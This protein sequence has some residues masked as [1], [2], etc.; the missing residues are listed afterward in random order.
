MKLII[1]YDL[2]DKARQAKT[3]FSLKRHS[4]AVGTCMAFVSP[5]LVV[6]ATIGDR[7]PLE[8]TARTLGLFLYYN[9]YYWLTQKARA[10]LEMEKAN[11]SLRLLSYKLKDIFV[12]TD[13][14]LLQEVVAYK[15]KYSLDFESSFF[16]RIEQKKYLTVPVHS[17]WDNNTRSLVQEHIIG[18]KEYTLAHGEPEQKKVYSLGARKLM[19][20]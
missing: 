2:P 12:D 4:K 19:Q 3:G 11:E 1:N 6:D 16:P 8:M 9:L 20:K 18:S 17:D 7:T 10:G 15:T 5:L 13:P 14:S